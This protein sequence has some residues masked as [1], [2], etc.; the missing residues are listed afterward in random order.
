MLMCFAVLYYCEQLWKCLY[1]E[2][3]KEIYEDIK[4]EYF[5]VKL[6]SYYE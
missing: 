3:S 6:L 5:E 1:F 2:S 4:D